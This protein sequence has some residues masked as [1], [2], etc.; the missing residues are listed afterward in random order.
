[1]GLG[2]CTGVCD[3]LKLPKLPMVKS[4]TKYQLFA[5]CNT[6][7]RWWNKKE[8]GNPSRCQCC[9]LKLRLN[10]RTGRSRRA[11]V[12]LMPRVNWL[13]TKKKSLLE[14]FTDI[15]IGYVIY[16]PVNF[17]VLPLF[18]EGIEEYSIWTTLHIS[19]IYT[20]IAILRKYSLR[21]F[22]NKNEQK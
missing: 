7:A 20:S 21:R 6:C 18:T 17:F 22:F 9:G 2:S 8:F 5:Y 14:S 19:F 3:L 1:M 10:S 12:S 4:G 15:L 13:Q 16:L 11:R